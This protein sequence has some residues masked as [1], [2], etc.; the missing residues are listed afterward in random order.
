MQDKTKSFLKG[1]ASGIGACLLTALVAVTIYGC[2]SGKGAKAVN[3]SSAVNIIGEN[4]EAS[5]L[6]GYQFKVDQRFEWD[7]V[8]RNVTGSSKPVYGIGEQLGY[9]YTYD[10]FNPS[11]DFSYIAISIATDSYVRLPCDIGRS[12][13]WFASSMHILYMDA[14]GDDI[15]E[16]TY[17][18]VNMRG[19]VTF[20]VTSA[21]MNYC[22]RVIIEMTSYFSFPDLEGVTLSYNGDSPNDGVPLGSLFVARSSD[23]G[24]LFASP[25]EGW[26][27]VWQIPSKNTFLALFELN[28][29]F[30]NQGVEYD[31]IRFHFFDVGTSR[32]ERPQRNSD[33]SPNVAQFPI[34]LYNGYYR[35]GLVEY[36]SNGTSTMV[37]EA[38]YGMLSDG[39]LY[40]TSGRWASDN[41]RSITYYTTGVVGVSPRFPTLNA[42]ELLSLASEDTS[43]GSG[44][45]A[46]A[47]TDTF[48]L[49]TK[50]FGAFSVIFNMQI[51]PFVTLGTFML[52]P[53]VVAV[54]LFVVGLFKR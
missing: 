49:I 48:G 5:D 8:G 31:G 44:G 45:T 46:V 37:W 54:I 4:A 47:I 34:G 29:V 32:V 12:G 21:V 11:G 42:I 2:S 16:K 52:I 26:N 35:L 41:Y 14:D 15:D 36:L 30:T 50:A 40:H 18:D 25:V 19:W 33:G 20:S 22:K 17:N 10:F 38:G 24:G 7:N 43:A 13:T 28:F 39:N 27:N 53:L 1:L 3:A 51:F 6:T 9:V 23:L